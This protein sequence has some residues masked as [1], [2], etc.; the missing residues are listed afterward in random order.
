MNVIQLVND[1]HRRDYLG[2]YGNSWI[3]TPNLDRFAARS[4]VFDRYYIA[5]YPTVPNRWD[6]CVGRY[7]FPHRGWQPLDR[8]DTTM[9]QLLTRQGVHTEMIWD[10]PMLA[11]DDY[12]YT[13]GFA[14][15]EFVHGQKGDPWIT[16]PSF[17]IQHACQP[18]KVKNLKSME[19]YLRN[20]HGRQYER[21]FPV[22][23]TMSA[24]RFLRASFW[25]GSATPSVRS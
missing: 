1:T 23:R 21:Q 18:H 9:A 11:K 24:V 12:N 6:M 7:G 8:G 10:T 25:A 16:S 13:R 19:N 5:S 15:I 14:G 4:A 20:H 3:H 22:A 2:C 17:P